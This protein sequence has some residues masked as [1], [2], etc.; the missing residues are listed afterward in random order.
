MSL[1]NVR[2]STGVTNDINAKAEKMKCLMWSELLRVTDCLSQ[3]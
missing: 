3:V 1:P 2:H